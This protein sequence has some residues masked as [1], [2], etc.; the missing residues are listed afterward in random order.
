MKPLILLPHPRFVTETGGECVLPERGYVVVNGGRQNAKLTVGASQ[1]CDLLAWEMSAAVVADTKPTVSL[2]CVPNSVGYVEGYEITITADGVTVVAETPAGVFRGVQTVR[3][4]VIQYGRTLPT[5]RVRDWP[6]YANRGVMLDVSRDKV[7]TMETLLNLVDLLASWKVN[8]IQ[9][10]TEHTFAYR[11]HPAVWAEASPI[12]GAEILEL[13][14]FCQERFIELV[15]NQNSFGHMRRWLTKPEYRHLAEAPDGCDTIWGWF[16]EPFTLYPADPE[17]LELVRSMFDELLPHFSSDQIN[18]GC[19][20]TI[21]LGQG[22]SKEIV[23]E[24][25]AGRVYLDFLLKIYEDVKRRGKTMQFWGDIL[26]NHP[27][28]V[29]ELPRD[30]IALEWGYEA[31][32]PFDEHGAIF[33]ESGIPFYVCPGTSSWRTVGGR[34][35]NA[36]E[37]LRN[38]AMNGLKNGAVGYLIT[39]WG[40]EGHWQPQSVS[41]V[42]FGYGAA[43]AW[44][45]EGNLELNV[46]RAVDLFGV[47]DSAG[48]ASTL[49]STLGNVYQTTGIQTFNSTILFNM[50]QADV[51]V[52]QNTLKLEDETIGTRLDKTMT[53]IDGLLNQLEEVEMSVLDANLIKDEFTWSAH[54]L[55]HACLRMLWVKDGMDRGEAERLRAAA[56]QLMADH[57][58]IWHGRNRHGGYRESRERLQKMVDTYA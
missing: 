3:Q 26:M 50:L 5:L 21:D 46:T 39:D 20:E 15:P 34:T 33:A 37:N 51:E 22:R 54:M 57:D 4:L 11:A 38:A 13:D 31:G 9:L 16:D 29:A 10:Y 28:L 36:L 12:T 24:L 6:D 55:R 7:P 52:I 19:D 58:V 56:I 2:N 43:V 40:D 45:V 18:V 30:V 32:H 27:E 49:F 48:L 47:G 42:P 53:E 8:Q 41:Y 25:G 23:A 1:L 35:D 17:S 44:Y 14:A